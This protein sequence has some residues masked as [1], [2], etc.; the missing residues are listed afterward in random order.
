[1]RRPLITIGLTTFNALDTVKRAINSAFSQTWHPIEVVAVDDC[2]DDGTFFLLEQIAEE[3]S[4]LRVFRNR[5]N[6]GVSVSRNRILKE[7]RGE[8]VVFFDDDDQS[9]PERITE[10]Y[11]RIID[12]E[13]RF[14]AGAPVVCYTARE[15][16]YPNGERFL[17]PTMGQATAK[18][19]PAGLAVAHRIL[20]GTPLEDAYGACPT[21]SQMARLETFCL[22]GGFDPNLRRG[23][24]TD[25]NIRLASIGGHFVG[26]AHPLVIQ[27]MTKTSDK[28]LAEEYRNAKIL[29]RKHRSIIGNQVQY[30]FCCDWLNL[31]QSWL[32]CHRIE[33]ACQLVM[34][35][36]KHPV[37]SLARLRAAFNNI[38]L[39]QLF[40][41]F[42]LA[43]ESTKTYD[44]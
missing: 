18:S 12:Y 41:R 19:A 39:N 8:F 16:N 10:Q 30:N 13:K 26:I 28:S 7:A 20:I 24:D 3:N 1:M 29:L 21:C 5:V 17:A 42:H 31:K 6:G 43:D 2:S 23:E 33:F 9:V 15:I 25:F 11:S 32:E 35:V 14:A 36:I 4:K 22:V 44:N 34:L 40:S 38:K 37:L 27:N